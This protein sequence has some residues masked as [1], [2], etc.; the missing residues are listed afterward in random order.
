M[1]RTWH[2]RL[3]HVIVYVHTFHKRDVWIIDWFDLNEFDS[4]S[5]VKKKKYEPFTKAQHF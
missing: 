4:N 1:N 5:R 2:D 3:R